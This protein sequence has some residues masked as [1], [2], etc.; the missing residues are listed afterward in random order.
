MGTLTRLVQ[1]GIGAY[2]ML[3]G[4]E[5]AATGGLTLAPSFLFGLALLADGVGFKLPEI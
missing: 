1:I 3:P 2:L 5:D 4:V